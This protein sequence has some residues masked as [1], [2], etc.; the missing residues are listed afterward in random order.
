MNV[1]QQKLKIDNQNIS[2]SIED[3]SCTEVW[4]KFSSKISDSEII[5]TIN[6]MQVI[7]LK[8]FFSQ[9]TLIY[10]DSLLPN[11]NYTFQAVQ[12]Q[13]GTISNRSEKVTAATIDTTTNN[14]S[15]SVD[16]LGSIQSTIDG[17]WG[18]SNDDLWAVGTFTSNVSTYKIAH[19][20]GVK[21]QFLYPKSF[22]EPSK[23][24]QAGDILAIYG[25]GKN[26]IWIVGYGFATNPFTREDSLWAFAAY[27][28]G[29]DWINVSPNY[30]GVQLLGI[31]LIDNNHVWAVGTNGTILF[32]NGTEWIKQ[33]S[34][35]SYLLRDIYGV[36]SRNIYVVGYSQTHAYGIS[37]KYN[38]TDWNIEEVTQP[39]FFGAYESVWMLSDK[40][41]WIAGDDVFYR[42][43]GIRWQIL[44][45]VKP[46]SL[47]LRI[48][49]NGSNNIFLG[50]DG[51]ALAH[52]NGKNW[53]LFE[54]IFPGQED[55][56]LKD[57]LVLNDRIYFV[58]RGGEGFY[59]K[60]VIYSAAS[61]FGK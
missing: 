12:Y 24:I 29:T 15:W 38:G 42:Y 51:G 2:L 43:N 33:N 9:D 28:N 31:W 52:F 18:S 49:G 48:R 19:Y 6:D 56:Y 10:I 11:R 3:V 45:L 8:S 32:Y 60:G 23:D 46:N 21:W 27:W 37:L 55:F 53:N 59:R 61:Y 14:Y 35:T 5:I 57:I 47:F 16:T 17:I 4:L 41:I 25:T 7:Q 34:G 50:I 58:G 39:G 36:D 30:P 54:H 13:N 1:T 44:D 26:N 40:S 20:N 22:H